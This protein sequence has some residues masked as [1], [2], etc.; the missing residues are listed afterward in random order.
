MYP[1]AILDLAPRALQSGGNSILDAWGGILQPAAAL[2]LTAFWQGAVVA[3]GLALCLRLAPRSP[4][5]HRF[6]LW[7]AGFGALIALQILPVISRL[8]PVHLI[9]ARSLIAPAGAAP[10]PHAWLQFNAAWSLVIAALW[11]AASLYRAVDLTLHSL[12]LYRL[13]KTAVPVQIEPT[14]LPRSLKRLSKPAI[15]VCTTSD[16]ERPSVIGFF[17]PR[18]LIPHWLFPRLTPG[19]LDQIVLHETEHLRRRDDWTN[20]LQKLCLVL[21]PLDPGLVWIER[22]LCREREMA[23]DD[24]VIGITR[25]PRAYA[26]CLT[27]L[28]ERGLER[29]VGL[30]SL[31]AWQ[32]RPELVRRVHSIL[33]RKHTF[34]PLAARV[35]LG[36]LGCVLLVGAMAL[37]HCPRLV[38]FAPRHSTSVAENS[39]AAPLKVNGASV[40]KLTAMVERHLKAEEGAITNSRGSTSKSPRALASEENTLDAKAQPIRHRAADSFKIAASRRNTAAPPQ[41]GA[42]ATEDAG[43]CPVGAD[44]GPAFRSDSTFIVMSTWES[45]EF[46]TPERRQTVTGYSDAFRVAGPVG[47]PAAQRVT[48]RVTVTRMYLKIFSTEDKGTTWLVIQ[49]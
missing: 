31:G 8:A 46:A 13:W 35:V 30:L 1:T 11:L 34:S 4:A 37:A 15:Q 2:V 29:R 32:A 26:A 14:S 41:P 40:P 3:A 20:L 28:A 36:L 10:A 42:L 18:V 6:F 21:F 19:E 39:T 25:A 49:L 44:P 5:R 12:H 47:P 17:A 24:G 7:A 45:F 9:E 48:P 43:L 38:A 33:R 23:C 16:L 22:Q 27:S